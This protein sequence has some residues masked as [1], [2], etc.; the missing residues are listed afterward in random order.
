MF[1][2]VVGK[3][4]FLTSQ[5]DSHSLLSYCISNIQAAEITICGSIKKLGRGFVKARV[6]KVITNY[7][8]FRSWK[9]E[10]FGKISASELWSASPKEI[11]FTGSGT[12]VSIFFFAAHARKISVFNFTINLKI[13]AFQYVQSIYVQ[14]WKSILERKKKHYRRQVFSSAQKD[15][16]QLSP[17]DTLHFNYLHL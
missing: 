8:K 16:F 17:T 7:I 4:S 5:F 10:L 9:L 15:H 14:C 12:E 1:V 6:C 13:A 11:S 3:W 2:E